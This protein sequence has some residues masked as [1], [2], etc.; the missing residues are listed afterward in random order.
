MA[1]GLRREED[2]SGPL[3]PATRITGRTGRMQ[4]EIP[5]INPA[6]KP[7]MMRLIT[8]DALLDSP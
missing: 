6:T 8:E 5:A 7:M 2:V 1:I 4:G 3:L